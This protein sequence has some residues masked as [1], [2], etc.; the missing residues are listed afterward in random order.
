MKAYKIAFA[1]LLGLTSLSMSAQDSEIEYIFNPHW[2]LQ[3]AGGAQ[4]TRGE[5]DF[6][7]LISGNAQL[8]IGY[9]FTP[10]FGLRLNANAWQS[11][12]GISYHQ[13]SD[14]EESWK[15]NY[16]APMLDLDLNLTNWFWGFNPM[17]RI[18]WTI[19]GGAGANIA[20]NNDE[21]YDVMDKLTTTGAYSEMTDAHKQQ[22]MDNVWTGTKAFLTG[23]L[24]TGID[25][26]ISDRVS[27]GIEAQANML[28]DRY[29]SKDA[30]N[31]DWYFNALASVKIKLGKTYTEKQKPAPVAAPVAVPAQPEPQIIEK[32]VET[33]KTIIEVAPM[34]RNIFFDINSSDINGAEKDKVA[35]I[36]DYLISYPDT[37]IT[38]SGYA[39]KNTG[40]AE[41]NEKISKA[42]TESVMQALKDAGIAEDRITT[43]VKGSESGQPFSDDYTKNRVAICIAE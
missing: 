41:I 8:G 26:R 11:K 40:T 32:P 1:A 16:V 23:R 37:K 17:R 21:A 33:V 4:Y 31:A 30:S 18:D 28:S 35:D 38:I 29:N 5:I 34:R 42:R 7:D 12:A 39:D 20:F 22:N 25:F 27:A 19:F 3:I 14:I 2:E 15:W 6:S 10:S 36:V 24:G 43:E 13:Y 9:W